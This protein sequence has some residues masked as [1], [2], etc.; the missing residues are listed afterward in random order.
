MK[1]AVVTGPTGT[2]GVNLIHELISRG[3]LV[4]AVCRP[5]SK[6]S[7]AV[8]K[9]PLVRTVACELADMPSLTEWIAAPQDAFYH[10]AWRGTAGKD[11]NDAALQ[12]QNAADTLAA[13]SAA[14]AMGCKAF[15]GAGSQAEYGHA[16]GLLSPDTPCAPVTEYGKAKLQAGNESRALCQ[17]LGMRHIWCRI[18]SI[19]GP[20]D[21]ENTMVMQVL[22]TLLDG[23]TPQCT[24]GEQ[25]WDY[26][27]AKDLARAMADLATGGRDGATYCMGSGRTRTLRDF[28]LAMRDAVDPTLGVDFGAIPYYPNQAMHLAADITALKRDIGFEPHYT[29]EQGIGE[30]IQWLR[31][32]RRA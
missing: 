6:R 11:R 3:V 29:F 32:Q 9:D 23:K 16:A 30:T 24:L 8:P 19:F 21:G 27:Y 26:L 10:L 20:Y 15:I 1:R 7:G 13:V 28:I 4:T 5:Q 12:M 14:G 18:L 17:T 2:V 22:S 31:Q 25:V